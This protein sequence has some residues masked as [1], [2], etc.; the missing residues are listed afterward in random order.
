MMKRS[1]LFSQHVGCNAILSI[2]GTSF[3]SFDISKLPEGGR[4]GGHENCHYK[5]SLLYVKANPERS[6]LLH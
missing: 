1:L 5:V 4:G 3:V 2:Q 6:N